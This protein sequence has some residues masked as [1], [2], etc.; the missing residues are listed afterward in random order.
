MRQDTMRL[1]NGRYFGFSA[2]D[3]MFQSDT[4][5]ERKKQLMS[6]GNKTLLVPITS[7]KGLCGAT[8]SGIVREVKAMLLNENRNDFKILA[9]GE[10]G[11]SALS[12]PFPDLL[13]GSVSEVALPMNYPT[14]ASISSQINEI[15]KEFDKVVVIYN[16]FVTTIKSDVTHFTLYPRHKFLQYFNFLKLYSQETPDKHTMNPALFDLYFG[17][18]FYKAL[19]NNIASEQ[20]A[21]MNAMENASKNAK[22]IVE[23]LKL[24]ANKARQ[25][26]ITME[27][28]EIISG[29][30]AV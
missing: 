16:S 13:L 29:A 4:Y 8:N 22:E 12:R 5:L 1:D 23:K 11:T 28:V 17:S 10:K 18:N 19:L 6:K 21:R 3:K 26:R 7:D 27:L 20:C 14:A 24:Q 15:A 2:I 9:V 30:S 25:A